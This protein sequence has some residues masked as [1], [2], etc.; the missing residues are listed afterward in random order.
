[1]GADRT[2]HH[3]AAPGLWRRGGARQRNPHYVRARPADAARLLW[4][5]GSDRRAGRLPAA[6]RI[7]RDPD[8]Y[9]VRGD[10][11]GVGLAHSV[12]TQ[13]RSYRHWAV[14]PPEADR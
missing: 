8:R 9:A 7:I 5:L 3:S 6:I 11:P 14:Y 1:M 2:R 4:E 12:L 13:Y 10:L